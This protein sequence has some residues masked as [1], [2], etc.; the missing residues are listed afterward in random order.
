MHGS[1]ECG[2]PLESPARRRGCQECG[3]AGCQSC[4]IEVAHR[5][6]CRWCATLVADRPA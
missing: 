1:C 4:V 5:T 6:Y 2:M 3:T